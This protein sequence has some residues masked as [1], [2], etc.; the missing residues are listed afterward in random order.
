MTG[1]TEHVI[2]QD[3]V[4]GQGMQVV[5]IDGDGDQDVVVAFSFTD[6]VHLYLNQGG[7]GSWRKVELGTGIVAV[8]L[9]V[10]DVDADGDLDVAAVGLFAREG[11]SGEITWYENPGDPTGAWITHAITG[12]TFDGPT[13]LASTDLDGDGRPDLVVG[14]VEYSGAGGGVWWLRNEGGGFDP[15]VAID[16]DLLD[17]SSVQVGDLGGDGAIDVVAAGRTSGEI[18]LYVNDGATFTKTT[19]ASPAEP[20]DLQ[21]ANM[22]GDPELEIVAVSAGQIAYYDPPGWTEVVIS[23]FPSVRPSRIAAADFDGDGSVDVAATTT[24]LDGELRLFTRGGGG[25]ASKVVRTG[26]AGFNFVV[27]GDLDGDGVA[28]LLSS[29]YAHTDT[30]D[31]IAWWS[32][33]R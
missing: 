23:E 13:A 15:P 6:A 28:D 3:I 19:I 24:E 20:T 25:F 14:S 22:D 2:D 10:L 21:L 32:R 1:F 9:E 33:S 11:G 31:V 4:H 30:N 5:D 27:A 7:G 8:E 17:V 16:P 18:A 29:T 26:Y 12:H